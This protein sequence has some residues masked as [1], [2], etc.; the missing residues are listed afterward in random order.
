[1]CIEECT[2]SDKNVLKF[3]GLKFIKGIKI[4]RLILKQDQVVLLDPNIRL[5]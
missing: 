5:I 1:M 3:F 2:E 4:E